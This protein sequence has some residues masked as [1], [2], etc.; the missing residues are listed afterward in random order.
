M[1]IVSEDFEKLA[2]NLDISP[3]MYKY[4]EDRYKEIAKYLETRGIDAAF[5]PQGSFRTGTVV[6]PLKDGKDADYD[7]DVV[8]ELLDKKNMVS[9]ANVKSEVGAALKGSQIYAPMLRPEDDRC[10]TLEYKAIISGIGF[11]MDIVPCVHECDE[12]ITKLVS[13]GVPGDFAKCAIAI[14]ERTTQKQYHWRA[15][16]PEGYGCWFDKINAPF[17]QLNLK[18][19]KL[20]LL[21]ENRNLFMATATIDDV[22]DYYIRSTLQ[23][24][25]QILKR[26]R[27]I[28]YSRA[29]K[30]GELRPASVIITTLAA[31]IAQRS[32]TASIEGLLQ[33]ISNGLSEYGELLKGH[34]PLNEAFWGEKNYITHTKDKWYIPNPVNPEDNYADS[35]TNATAQLFFKWV[36]AVQLDLGQVPALNETNY[37]SGLQ[38]GLGTDFVNESLILPSTLY[39]NAASKSK[40]L[41]HPTK[42]WGI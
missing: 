31:Q 4:A 25:I 41:S 2:T 23:R 32:P 20:K 37:L 15:S 3:T 30:S 22:P 7:I 13:L 33:H 39:A 16:N 34:R 26:H 42:P 38:R 1:R 17:L 40:E 21:N 28:F 11:N 14:T 9:P 12:T 5:Y 27:D 29:D 35:W 18:E 8:S 19:K 24:A 10:W 36:D 6:R